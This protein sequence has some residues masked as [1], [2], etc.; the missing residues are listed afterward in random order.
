M[1]TA[2]LCCAVAA[3]AVGGCG[4]QYV[5]TVPDQVAPAG[6][7]VRTIVRLQRHEFLRLTPAVEDAALRFRVDDGPARAAF[8][9][10]DGY[11]AVALP[12]PDEPGRHEVS[13]AYQDHYGDELAGAAPLYVFPPDARIVAV[14]VDCLPPASE[15]EIAAKALQRIAADARVL[16]LTRSEV[17]E[18]ARVHERLE[19]GGYPDGPVLLWQR[20]R[21]RLVEGTWRLPKVEYEVRLVNQLSELRED[22][23]GLG[24][25]VC[26][27]ELAA[28]AFTDAGLETVLV[29]GAE[30]PQDTVSRYTSWERLAET[31]L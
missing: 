14:D 19:R 27:S 23:P 26:D 31:G 24:A 30:V 12:A 18:H 10:E 22:F 20:R 5:L 29:G 4:G 28:K 17:R 9:D 3:L 13:I 1:R 6:G 2:W 25:G 15:T 7:Q 21:W 11:A 16:Y 8:T